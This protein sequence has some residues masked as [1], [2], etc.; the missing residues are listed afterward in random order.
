MA[1]HVCSSVTSLLVVF[2][3]AIGGPGG[4]GYDGAA[5]G[6]AV[7]L[8]WD[9]IE[10]RRTLC[11]A[12]RSL[13]CVGQRAMYAGDT[14]TAT[15]CCEQLLD[16]VTTANDPGYLLPS[17]LQLT[18][19]RENAAHAL[20]RLAAHT[21]SGPCWTL[22]EA[23]GADDRGFG[24]GGIGHGSRIVALALERMRRGDDARETHRTEQCSVAQAAVLAAMENRL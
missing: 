12:S 16:F 8:D 17:L 14:D 9:M 21:N 20:M 23:P 2:C 4:R 24:F 5:Y 11:C 10:L 15:M 18:A 19:V 22:P 13:G 3:A 7:E 1:L 6:S